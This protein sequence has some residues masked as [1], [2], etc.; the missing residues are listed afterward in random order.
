MNLC[1]LLQGALLKNVLDNNGKTTVTTQYCKLKA[2]FSFFLFG[3]PLDSQVFHNHT[4]YDVASKSDS[5][6]ISTLEM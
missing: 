1:Q 5:A 6:L 2:V 4:T 3:V